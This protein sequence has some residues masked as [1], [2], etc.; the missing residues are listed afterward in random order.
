M[1]NA[2]LRSASLRRKA[3]NLAGRLPGTLA[4]VLAVAALA[5]CAELPEGGHRQV[6]SLLEARQ[7]KTVVQKW[8]YSC[9]A[10]ALATV[11]TYEH[12]DPV[13]EREVA[14]GMLRQ[15]SADLVRQRLGFSLLDLKR[16][17]SNRG[18]TADGYRN[19]SV[20]DLASFGPAI[21]PI[22]VR[23]MSHFVVFRGVQGDRVLLSDPAWGSRTLTVA[24]FEEVWLGRM[25]F[26]VSRRDH[27]LPAN[28]L[29]PRAEDFWA[30]SRIKASELE[31]ASLDAPH[32][33][34]EP[35]LAAG[36]AANDA[37]TAGAN[38]N[39]SA[40]NELTPPGGF[41]SAVP[42]SVNEPLGAKLSGGIDA[43]S[44]P[45]P[46][47]ATVPVTTNTLSASGSG[48]IT[49]TLSQGSG[50]APVTASLPQIPSTVPVAASLPQIPNTVP[51]TASLPQSSGTD[52]TVTNISQ[53]SSSGSV[54]TST[55]QSSGTGTVTVVG[56]A[57]A[58]ALRGAS[59]FLTS[60][61]LP[62]LK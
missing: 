1:T 26:T 18:F 44:L 8:D 41:A 9:G 29:R 3:G 2:T 12:G 59:G 24:Q 6:Y 20:A 22:A 11:L 43:A 13:S 39:L 47:S 28:H 27:A 50:T 25:G 45:A 32:L 36:A 57:A 58:D 62:P 16:Y 15:T 37:V 48:P 53:S 30:S 55:Q 31:L 40:N 10:A 19:L 46:V 42:D 38:L 33:P 7:D 35:E 60:L 4:S 51:V 5:G 52:T 17:A 49:A 14:A 34:G 21:V 23:N 54:V 56:A 61:R